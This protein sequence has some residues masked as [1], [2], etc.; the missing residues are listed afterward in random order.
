MQGAFK[1]VHDA[2]NVIASSEALVTV[3]G[4]RIAALREMLRLANLR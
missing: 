3:A 1:D 4:K 2:L